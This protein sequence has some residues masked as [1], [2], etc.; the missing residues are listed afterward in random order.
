MMARDSEGCI[1]QHG[2]GASPYAAL[3]ALVLCVS[4]MLGAAEQESDP[5]IFEDSI[6]IELVR[7]FAGGEIMYDSLPPGFPP[8]AVPQGLRV[9]GG[10]DFG[11]GRQTVVLA[12]ALSPPEA[13]E[14]LR[15]AFLAEEGWQELENPPIGL[16]GIFV[17]RE[18][19]SSGSGIRGFASRELCH[20]EFGMLRF[21]SWGIE[22]MVGL[23]RSP[24]DPSRRGATCEEQRERRTRF[25]A[26]QENPLSGLLPELEPPEGE[27]FPGGRGGGGDETR[28]SASFR[29]PAYS[30]GQLAAHFASQ[31]EEQGW[32]M[33]ARWDGELSAGH[34]WL[35][36][37]PGEG[38]AVAFFNVVERGE[39][40]FELSFRAALRP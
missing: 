16:P 6:P 4:S 7:Y 28:A 36:E 30:P 5:A 9:A 40:E 14:A 11:E 34:S 25:G 23:S 19:P 13:R 21:R 37:A 26:L 1:I 39:G 38:S 31:L 17:P 24:M 32:R 8:F 29:N 2:Y 27:F 15:E 20:D 35:R 18:E 22:G 3:G 33:D 10:H 12:S